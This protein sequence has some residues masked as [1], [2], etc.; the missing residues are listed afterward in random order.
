MKSYVV[1]VVTALAIPAIAALGGALAVFSGYDD[2]PGG[3]L[4]GILLIMG[5]VALGL[6]AAQRRK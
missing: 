3:V 2:A 6:R 5:A 1:D 4:M